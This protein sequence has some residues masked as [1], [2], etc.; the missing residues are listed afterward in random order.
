MKANKKSKSYN[1]YEEVAER[2]EP[3]EGEPRGKKGKRRPSAAERKKRTVRGLIIAGCVLATL[4]LLIG[5]FAIAGYGGA[6]TNK[7]MVSMMKPVKYDAAVPEPKLVKYGDAED[8]PQYYTFTTDKPFRVLQLTDVHLGAGAFSIKKDNWAL[9]ACATLIKKE[10]PDLV[11]VTG[12]IAYP[13]PFQSGTFNN[14]REAEMF[15]TL[16]EQ[17]QVY[18]VPVYGNHD[19]EVYS[20]YTRK[21]ISDFYADAKWKHCLFR[22]GFCDDEKGYGNSMIVIKN[23]DDLISQVLVLFDSHSYKESD[24]WGTKWFYDNIHKS[25]IDWYKT[26]ITRLND[27][28]KTRFAELPAADRETYAK[29][30]MKEYKSGECPNYADAAD[31]EA[32]SMIKSCAFFHIALR[33]YREAWSK[34]ITNKNAEDVHYVYGDKG[35]AMKVHSDL[36]TYGIWCGEDEDEVF[37]TMIDLGSTQGLF[38]GHDHLNNFSVDYTK[39]INEGKPDEK[40]GTIRC[41]YGMSIDYLA[42]F[43]IARKTKQRG[44]TTIVF[45]QDGRM[46]IARHPLRDYADIGPKRKT[47][48]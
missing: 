15:A 2:C 35:E 7:K 39:K 48:N 33:E 19:T 8:S 3:C 18:W 42:Y 47:E 44:G 29:A 1:Y 20:T 40:T 31:F 14:K 43:G 41:T 25:Q 17:L 9:N 16:M 36:E 23:P 22:H 37:E 45:T 5:I 26:E 27:I 10:K 38:C 30:A 28:N 32:N 24:P 13:V 4:A 6:Q 34:Y 21:D 12:D 46:D 11:I